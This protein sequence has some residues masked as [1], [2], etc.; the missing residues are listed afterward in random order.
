MID[1][2][3]S[4]TYGNG[5]PS[6][7][8]QKGNG[9][10]PDFSAKISRLEERDREVKAHEKAHRDVA[11]QYAGS[12]SLDSFITGPDGK[13]YADSGHVSID[14]SEISGDPEA[15]VKKMETVEE[16]ALAPAT[17]S[18]LSPEDLTVAAEAREKKAKAQWQLQKGDRP[19]STFSIVA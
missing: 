16:A 13:R 19:Y 8:A 6:T 12:I 2:N 15:T 4:Q 10:N 11:G 17:F 9:S 7:S 18:E 5:R 3:P 14:T 1:F